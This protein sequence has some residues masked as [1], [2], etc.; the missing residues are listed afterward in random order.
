M[1]CIFLRPWNRSLYYQIYEISTLFRVCLGSTLKEFTFR[2]PATDDY[3]VVRSLQSLLVL[4]ELEIDVTLFINSHCASVL[5]ISSMLPS[6]IRKAV[7]R[8]DNETVLIPEMS[9][10]FS[11]I[12]KART[13]GHSKLED[14]AIYVQREVENRTGRSKSALEAEDY[15]RRELR[16]LV[17]RQGVKWI[18]PHLMQRIWRDIGWVGEFASRYR[19]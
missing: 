11:G 3:S 12:A 7:L 18:Y 13:L 4:E 19:C 1:N 9:Q 16:A 6:S 2:V 8:L 15:R 5:P 10:L 17:E 14:I